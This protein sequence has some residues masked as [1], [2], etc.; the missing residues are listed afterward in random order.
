[1]IFANMHVTRMVQING[2]FSDCFVFFHQ[3]C[4]DVQLFLLIFSVKLLI[5]DK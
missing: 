1:M 3:F 2:F 4:V 5:G